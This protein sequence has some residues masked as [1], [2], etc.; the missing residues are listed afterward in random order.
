[1]E[2]SQEEIKAKMNIHQE[3]MKTAVH[4]IQFELED[5]I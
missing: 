4:S 3:K 2:S 5:S 1:M